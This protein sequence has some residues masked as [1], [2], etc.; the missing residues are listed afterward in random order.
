MDLIGFIIASAL[1]TVMPGPDI[2]Y[3]LVQGLTRGRKAALS[4]SFGLSSGLLVHTAAA[5]LGLSL[6]IAGSPIL[7]SIVKYAGVAYL[8]YMG[9]AA[10]LQRNK[11]TE[12]VPDVKTGTTGADGVRFWASYR[13]GVIMNLLNPKVILFFLAFLPHFLKPGDPT[14]AT[15]IFILGGV[16]AVQAVVIFSTVSLLAGTLFR[17]FAERGLSNR[18]VS[19]IN[20]VVYWGIACLFLFA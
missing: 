11:G 5:A 7:F 8:G 2:V 3:V 19:L 18:T 15:D 12:V 16:F 20:A 17:R 13:T 6:I 14:P 4:V 10:F 1:L 9:L